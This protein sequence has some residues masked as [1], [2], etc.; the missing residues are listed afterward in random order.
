MEL[1]K[2]VW[3]A[4]TALLSLTLTG[5]VVRDIFVDWLTEG[6]TLWSTLLENS[7]PIVLAL[8]VL[9]AGY[10]VYKRRNEA[11]LETVAKWQYAGAAIILVVA[12]EVVGLQIVQG[13][14]KPQLIIVQITIGGAVA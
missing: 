5:V 6:K 4:L 13:E 10:T 12:L 8:S 14:L 3:L 2:R 11:Y 1:N 9:F 7:I